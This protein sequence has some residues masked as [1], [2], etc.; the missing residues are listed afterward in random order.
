MHEL[1]SP[2]SAINPLV[3]SQS[4][5]WCKQTDVSHLVM[6]LHTLSR[7]MSG[8][9]SLLHESWSWLLNCDAMTDVVLLQTVYKALRRKHI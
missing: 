4:G 7:V 2:D 5:V 8:V 6:K 1:I 9:E 3:I